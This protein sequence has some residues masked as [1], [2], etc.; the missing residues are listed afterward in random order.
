ML[1]VINGLANGWVASHV[2][3]SFVRHGVWE[4]MSA[5]PM[6]LK[7]LASRYRGNAGHLH[8]GLR[9]LYELGWVEWVKA[10]RYGVVAGAGLA[11]QLLGD[12]EELAQL[13]VAQALATEK[14]EQSECLLR[15][16]DR[17]NASWSGVEPRVASL[18]DGA[19]LTPLL[20]HLHTLGGDL[21][22]QTQPSA[23]SVA[24]L[25]A[26]HTVFIQRGWGHI[27]AAGF[28]L[29][30]SGRA[31]LANSS[32]L[33]RV[34][35]YTPMLRRID[36]VLFGDAQAIFGQD[37]QGYELHLDRIVNVTASAMQHQSHFAELDTLIL[38]IFDHPPLATQ[39]RYIADMGCGD[40]SLL[41]RIYELIK[42][43]S[44]RG[45]ALAEY[46]LT[47][48]GVNYNT[49]SLEATGKMLA[50]L[51]HLLV[52]GSIGDPQQ[53][54]TD[55]AAAGIEDPENILHVRAFL[56]HQRPFLPIED[57]TAARRRESLNYT[58]VYVARDGSEIKPAHAVQG[59]V[60]HLRRWRL[61]I[62]RFG[63]LSLEAHCLRPNTVKCLGNMTES[64]HF[65]AF[66]AFSGQQ[67]VEASV[68]LMAAA[69][70]GLFPE[71]GLSRTFPE[72]LNFSCFS[73]HRLIPQFYTIRHPVRAD[74]SRL[75]YLNR[76]CEPSAMRISTAEI[77]RRVRD[78]PQQQMVL[79]FGGQIAAV[80]YTQRID[81]VE[82]LRSIDYA[83]VGRLCQAEGRYVQLLGLFV[84]PE[85][86]GRGFS[87]ALLDLMLVYGSLLD[88][89]DAIV[90]VTR[91]AHYSQYQAECSLDQYIELRDE[92]GQWVDPMLHFHASHGAVI[93]EVLPGFRPGDT[94]NEGA[95]VLIEY[96][97]RSE[98]KTVVETV[99]PHAVSTDTT[100][101]DK[102]VEPIVRS[103]VIEV[104]GSQ[105]S[106]AY[107]PQAPLMEMG[108]SSLE[109]LEL[110]RRLS[111][112]MG[113]PLPS[114]FFFSYGTSKAII[115]YFMAQAAVQSVLQTSVQSMPQTFATPAPQASTV[116]A[117]ATH[118]SASDGLRQ[119]STRQD[120]AVAI[121]EKALIAR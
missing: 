71:P 30:P 54:I 108:L 82:A 58:G 111:T 75:K 56:D 93:R 95:G 41:H 72:R 112:R 98:Q 99:D 1:E 15:W 9:L 106:T 25:R 119:E 110:R 77:K 80:L 81:S 66:K 100:G 28:Q 92:Q 57:K 11:R 16:L 64:A 19:L 47:L 36:D 13:P 59:L 114:T 40:G 5:R 74:L 2:I 23:I 103:A 97:L 88:G 73:L 115:G 65:D 55:L 90:G 21:L 68:F 43:R 109:L 105:R 94:D 24:A 67:L 29:T 60:E 20:A 52:R 38:R 18:L 69:E 31:L 35:S 14:S 3:G 6:A 12:L 85:M 32:A 62:S 10:D 102:Q 96:R 78:L 107:D 49:L 22:A 7:K 42:T 8:A 46:P 104:L 44:A 50:G 48:I 76:M 86:H 33:G 45:R 37:K 27:E 51:P 121:I 39:P 26:V 91:C 117:R 34:V 17:C 113:Q 84:A 61:A 79:E 116:A 120:Q 89:V 53:L 63:L 118:A 70:V 83:E 4:A 101:V 87:D